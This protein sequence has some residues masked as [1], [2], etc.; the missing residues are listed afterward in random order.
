MN[1]ALPP[2]P[3]P[4]RGKEIL[5]ETQR[6]DLSYLTYTLKACIALWQFST[7]TDK[8]HDILMKNIKSSRRKVRKHCCLYL[9][10]FIKYLRTIQQSGQT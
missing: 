6:E 7:K 2:V 4:T 3:N 8:Q 5:E 9:K 1:Q 10:S